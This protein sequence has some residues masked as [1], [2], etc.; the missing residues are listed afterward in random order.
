MLASKNSGISCGFFWL[1]RFWSSTSFSGGSWLGRFWS[2]S[3]LF[4]RVLLHLSLAPQREVSDPPLP[5]ANQ[6]LPLGTL[7]PSNPSAY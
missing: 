7:V 1:G 2:F 3:Q 4:R 6:G 5:E